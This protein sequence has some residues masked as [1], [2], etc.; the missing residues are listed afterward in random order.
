MDSSDF[1]SD[2]W[3]FSFHEL[4]KYDVIANIEYVKKVSKNSKISYLCH[5]QGCFQLI[6]GYTM[7]P[8]F[9]EESVDKFG[10]MGA[11]IKISDYNKIFPKFMKYFHMLEWLE[12]F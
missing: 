6:I 8:S 9:F 11:V 4:A 2:Y 5:S 7:N 1:T 10:T 12:Y 3:N